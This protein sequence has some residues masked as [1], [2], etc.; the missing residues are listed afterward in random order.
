MS[1]R[2]HAP[3]WI[4]L[5]VLAL[6]AG[7][8]GRSGT[9]GT[10]GAPGAAAPS[11]ATVSIPWGEDTVW[12]AAQLPSGETAKRS[13]TL[14]LAP[15]GNARMTTDYTGRGTGTDVGWWSERSDTVAIQFATID[16]KA[17]GTISSWI[18][19]GA[20]MKPVYYNET[21]WGKAGIAFQVRTAAA[22]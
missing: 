1:I 21:E 15:D 22:R 6:G 2:I 8:C 20:Q 17:S 12:A 11:A 5:V 9:S 4:A 14:Q 18:A 13:I 3:T 19:T 10:A 7:A 16:G